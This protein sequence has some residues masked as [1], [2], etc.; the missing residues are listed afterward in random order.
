MNR[1]S[2]QHS[3]SDICR[4]NQEL[5]QDYLD[6]ALPKTQSLE[7][8][9]HLRECQKC[10]A[11]LAELK[12]VIELLDG[13]P[14]AKLPENFDER[15]LASV[16]YEAYREMEPLRRDRIPVYLEEDFLPAFLRAASTRISGAVVAVAVAAGLAASW[17]PD[18]AIVVV[19]GGLIPE[20]VVRLQQA[21]RKFSLVSQRTES[22]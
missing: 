6:G 17:L 19:I 8:F 18:P 3:H 20:G 7:L 5:F 4:R 13:L 15:I 14:P 16:P 22:G 2:T 9:L 10:D 21:A 12:Q 1:D 11:A